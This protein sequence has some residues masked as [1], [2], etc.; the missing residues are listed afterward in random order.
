M[1][2][3]KIATRIS[4]VTIIGNFLLAI[5]KFLAGFLSNS[6]AMISDA[7][8]T[9]SDVATTIIAMVGVNLGNKEEDENHRYGHERIECV[10]SLLLAFILFV[11]GIEIGIEGIKILIENDYDSIKTPGLFALIAAII[12]I[13]MKE[14]M[15]QYTIR[16]AKKIKSDALKADAW[17][18]RSDSLSSIGALIG[19]VLSRAGYKFCDPIASVLISV[20]ICKVAIEIFIEATNKLVDKSCDEKQIDDIKQIVFKQK[21]VLGIDDIKTRIFGSKIYVDI[22]ISADGKKS[23]NETHKI[24]EEVHDKVEKHF[25]DIKHI[26]VH[27]NPYRGGKNEK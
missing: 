21:G 8:H 9:I 23:L 11:T 14:I 13:I 19:I 4:I 16:G 7:I 22:E 26:M 10:A 24:A 1:N 27:V 25:P 17:H 3:K 5:I 18:H 15:F 6:G 12:S 20:L 2:N